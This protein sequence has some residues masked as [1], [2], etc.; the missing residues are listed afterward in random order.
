MFV[1]NFGSTSFT[2]RGFQNLQKKGTKA[3]IHNGTKAGNHNSI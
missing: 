3:D 1:Q 2:L